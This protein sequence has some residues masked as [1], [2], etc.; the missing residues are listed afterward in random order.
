MYKLVINIIVFLFAIIAIILALSQPIFDIS[1]CNTYLYVDHLT[2]NGQRLDY[3]SSKFKLYPVGMALLI[4]LVVS[5]FI[6]LCLYMFTNLNII[7]NA[8]GILC[9]LLSIIVLVIFNVMK[10]SEKVSCQAKNPNYDP[11][12]A[13]Q[14]RGSKSGSGYMEYKNKIYFHDFYKEPEFIDGT[15]PCRTT[16][17]S[18]V[19]FVALGLYILV[20]L[21]FNKLIRKTFD[22]GLNNIKT[23]RF[24]KF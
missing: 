9:I 21:L 2:I 10:P 4:I 11:V 18:I 3:D 13:Q 15:F 7:R 1:T 20:Q 22:I 19:L 12:L 17:Y 8:I 23:R 24:S 14:L 6:E 5:I 16:E